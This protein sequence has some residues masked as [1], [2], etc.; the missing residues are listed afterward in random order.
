M[1]SFTDE[2]IFLAFWLT[3]LH[4]MRSDC[5]RF[6]FLNRRFHQL[7][8][9]RRQYLPLQPKRR[10]ATRAASFITAQL[11]IVFVYDTLELN[12]SIKQK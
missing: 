10:Q 1:I 2:T 3:S 8:I 12:A 11:F 9:M 7:E 5:P 4:R 6:V